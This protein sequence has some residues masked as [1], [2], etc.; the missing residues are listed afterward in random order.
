[1]AKEQFVEQQV[2]FQGIE[3]AFSDLRPPM[4]ALEEILERLRPKMLGHI[5]RGVRVEQLADA[6]KEK[7]IDV[8]ARRLRVY[9]ERGELP[10]QRKRRMAAPEARSAAAAG[11]H[12]GAP[13]ASGME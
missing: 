3:A 10:G 4:L 1:M 9:L 13:A 7:G 5:E 6:L 8:G 2:D 12:A 11:S